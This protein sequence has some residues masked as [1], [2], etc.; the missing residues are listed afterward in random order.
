MALPGCH[1]TCAHLSRAHARASLPGSP[2]HAAQVVLSSAAVHALC[3]HL[4]CKSTARAKRAARR[5]TAYH[6]VADGVDGCAHVPRY[7]AALA[8]RAE[9]LRRTAPPL[10]SPPAPPGTSRHEKTPPRAVRCST[11]RNLRAAASCAASAPLSCCRFPAAAAGGGSSCS[12][13]LHP[14]I[15]THCSV[16]SWLRRTYTDAA[17]TR[18]QRRRCAPCVGCTIGHQRRG[19]ARRR[20]CLQVAPSVV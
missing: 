11:S 12:C 19:D 13:S 5:T 20:A 15:R 9:R 2:V 14:D 10:L 16:L 7:D 4:L 17:L 18:H 8:R 3:T 6:A 1:G